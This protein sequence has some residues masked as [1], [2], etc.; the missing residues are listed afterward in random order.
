MSDP[1][2]TAYNAIINLKNQNIHPGVNY[3]YFYIDVEE[4][5]PD[6]DC[7]STDYSVNQNYLISLVQGAQAAGASVGIYASTYEWKLLFGSD[8]WSSSALTPL[9]LV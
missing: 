9:P 7:W 3:T 2:S 5:D 1:Y 4:C 6:D 8:S